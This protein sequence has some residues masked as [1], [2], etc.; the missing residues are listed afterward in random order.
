MDVVLKHIIPSASSQLCLDPSI[1]Y[2]RAHAQSSRWD[3]DCI[4]S[5]VIPGYNRMCRPYIRAL[6]CSATLDRSINCTQVP[7]R[8]WQERSTLN[9][10]HLP[11]A[12]SFFVLMIL[13]AY[14]WP[15]D[16]FTHR[17]TI[18]KA[19]LNKREKRETVR[20]KMGTR[21]WCRADRAYGMESRICAM[22]EA[23]TERF[24]G[25][26]T[27]ILHGCLSMCVWWAR[28]GVWNCLAYSLT[29]CTHQICMCV[30]AG[31][32]GVNYTSP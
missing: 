11:L 9:K 17:L 5:C 23:Q 25:Y 15:D 27:T 14:S 12:D 30:L 19:P 18:E 26:T 21:P 8:T 16:I 29:A 2:V 28:V 10:I 1:C 22:M 31:N 6:S 20:K 13:A 7:H 24:Q 32:E 3:P 4:V